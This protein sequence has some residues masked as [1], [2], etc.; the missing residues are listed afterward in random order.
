MPREEESKDGSNKPRRSKRVRF[1]PMAWWA[2]QRP[3][4]FGL[5]EPLTYDEIEHII[6]MS[7]KG[8]HVLT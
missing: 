5:K 3:N 2:G 1:K 7:H 6:A 8:R 4:T